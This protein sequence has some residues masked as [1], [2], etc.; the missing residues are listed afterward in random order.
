M[1]SLCFTARPPDKGTGVAEI[2]EKIYFLFCWPRRNRLRIPQG[3]GGQKRERSNASRKFFEVIRPCPKGMT[4]FLCR[5]PSGKEKRWILSACSA[6]LRWNTF[7]S[8]FIGLRRS[9]ARKLESKSC[10]HVF[11]IRR[12][13]IHKA[14]QA[15]SECVNYYAERLP[16]SPIFLAFTE[17]PNRLVY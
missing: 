13:Y 17:F 16:C 2:A 5:R 10:C 4:I 12:I 15:Q 14:F 11:V 8:I 3:G 9:F 6:A 1:E 7:H